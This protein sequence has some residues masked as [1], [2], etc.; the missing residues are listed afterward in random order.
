MSN[1]KKPIRPNIEDIPLYSPGRS[2]EE[3][4]REFKIS[5]VI[6]LASNENPFG[7]SPKALEAM[8]KFSKDMNIYPDKGCLELKDQIAVKLG[9]STENIVI[10]NGS[11]EIMLLAGLAFLSAKEEVIISKNTFSTYEIVTRLMD[12]DPVFVDLKDNA[13]DLNAMAGAITDKTK[14]IFICSPNNPTGTISTK[15][16]LDS[17][18]SRVPSNVI[19]IIDEAYGDYVVSKDYPDSLEYIK[20]K[21]NVLVLRTFSKIYGL[22]G[23]RIGYGIASP[24][25]IK[26]LDMVRLPFSVNRLAQLAAI[27]ALNDEGFVEKSLTNNSDGK[28]YL[29]GELDG[30][31]VSYQKTEAN[32]ICIKLDEKADIV[33]IDLMRSGIIIRPLTSFGMPYSIRVT[34]GTPEQNRGFIKALKKALG[35]G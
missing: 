22:A 24:E 19:V 25:I 13:Y 3:A 26:Y 12:G 14:L 4:Q 21:K 29:Y 31:G 7:P 18:L 10:G 11:D 17:F 8:K 23:L 9:L 32:F 28:T 15:K 6:K 27:A 1:N 16:D 35:K 33:F 2:A 5:G 30:L 34:I 20:G